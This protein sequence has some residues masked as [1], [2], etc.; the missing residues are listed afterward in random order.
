MENCFHNW[1]ELKTVLLGDVLPSKV[2]DGL[3]PNVKNCLTQITEETQEDLHNMASVMEEYDVKVLRPDV[4]SYMKK[5]NFTL[6]EE[7]IG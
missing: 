5:Q 1:G 2:Y 6:A 7:T 3:S 4:N